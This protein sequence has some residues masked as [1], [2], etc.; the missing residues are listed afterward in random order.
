VG[1]ETSINKL[2]RAQVE[3]E[4]GR[5]ALDIQGSF[6][7][8]ARGSLGA[9]EG[10]RWQHHMLS[11]PSVVIGGGTPNIQK[12]VIAERILGLPHDG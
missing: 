9:K 12:N 3:V 8:L 11:W 7:A 6:G 5:L 10:G 2:L 4:I 1:A